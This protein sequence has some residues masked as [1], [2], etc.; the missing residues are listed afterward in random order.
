MRFSVYRVCLVG[1]SVG[2]VSLMS[3]SASFADPDSWDPRLTDD[4]G[5]YWVNANPPPGTWYWRL[6][7]GEYQDETQSGGKHHIYYKC[8]DAIG[9][10]I[11]NQA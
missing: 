9:N 11:E 3:F 4:M 7:S 5:V 10:P 8:L 6:V 1:L 2:V